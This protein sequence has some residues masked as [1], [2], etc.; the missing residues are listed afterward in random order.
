MTEVLG[1]NIHAGI[2]MGLNNLMDDLSSEIDQDSF[3]LPGAGREIF[4]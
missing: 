1:Q 3:H 2:Q 4:I